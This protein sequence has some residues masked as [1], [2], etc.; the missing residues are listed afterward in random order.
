MSR[1]SGGRSAVGGRMSSSLELIAKVGSPLPS[2]FREFRVD[3]RAES[4][5][6]STMNSKEFERKWRPLESLIREPPS[7]LETPSSSSSSRTLPLHYTTG[8]ITDGPNQNRMD[9]RDLEP[10]DRLHEDQPRLQE[11]LRRA[12]GEA[13]QGDG[14]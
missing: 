2:Y 7:R 10:R 1:L 13:A 11:L 9:E 8:T 12:D 3:F 4:S 6:G 14:E 5:S